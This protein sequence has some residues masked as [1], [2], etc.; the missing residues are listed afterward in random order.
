MPLKVESV[1]E[2]ALNLTPM[3][4]VVLLL[5]I[6]FMVGTQFTEVEHQYDIQLPTVSDAQPL[7]AMPD[8]LVVNVRRDGEVFLGER[9]VSLADLEREL[10]E[11][12]A[13]FARQAVVVR[14]DG[15]GPY[16][17]VMTVL[18]VCRRARIVNIQLANRVE[19]P[20]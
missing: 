10:R 15:V 20:G 18:D 9:N 14:G 3:V 16:Q 6:F 13:R 17:N 4:D 8:E 12:Q 2:P 11:A 19:G 5:I 7:T 1:E